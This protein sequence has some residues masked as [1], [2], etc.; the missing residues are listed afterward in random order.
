MT[1]NEQHPCDASPAQARTFYGRRHGRPLRPGRRDLIETLLPQL[2]ITLP[3]QGVFDPATLFP[4][5]PAETWLEIGF[6][7]GE[8]LAAQAGSHP[9]TGFIGCEPFINGMASLLAKIK[10]EGLTNIRVFSDDARSLMDCLVEACL[11]RVFILFPDPWPKKRHAKRR[12]ISPRTV[13]ALAHTMKDNA[14]LR[15]ASDDPEYIRSMLEHLRRHE[16]FQWLAERPAHWRQRTPDWPATRYEA[17]A[18]QAGRSCA[19]LRFRRRPR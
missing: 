15:L 9:E 17:K 8:H 5:P 1:R 6:G 16:A 13:D 10:K 2:S 4:D 19:Y 11:G 7:G 3:D 14:E 18:L 12:L